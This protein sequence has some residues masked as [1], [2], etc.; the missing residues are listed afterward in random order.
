MKLMQVFDC[1]DMPPEVRQAFFD[2]HEAVNDVYV[3][4]WMNEFKAL[5]EEEWRKSHAYGGRADQS[6]LYYQWLV[7]N[8]ATDSEVLVAHWW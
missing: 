2:D 6:R 8:G 1:Q 7:D 4:V 3:K 5:T